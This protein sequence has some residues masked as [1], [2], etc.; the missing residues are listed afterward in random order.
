MAITGR[1][2]LRWLA[3]ASV[4]TESRPQF[5]VLLRPI[6]EFCEEWLTSEAAVRSGTKA[7]RSG[8]SNVVALRRAAG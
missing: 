3:G 1:E 5:E 2:V 7:R 6:E 8:G 4:T